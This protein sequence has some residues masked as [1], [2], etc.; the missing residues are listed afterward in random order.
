MK[1][2]KKIMNRV[3]S[4]NVDVWGYATLGAHTAVK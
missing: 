4:A 2:L 1:M 3:S